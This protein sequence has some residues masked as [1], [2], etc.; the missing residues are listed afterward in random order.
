MSVCACVLIGA[1][2][3]S[4]ANGL[5][6][7]S[8]LIFWA[9]KSLQTH[10][11]SAVVFAQFFNKKC[12]GQC[13]ATDLLHHRLTASDSGFLLTSVFPTGPDWL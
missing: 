4:T 1:L 3:Q 7:S 11:E 10:S 13:S 2:S 12:N 5:L 8:N 9:S 6:R